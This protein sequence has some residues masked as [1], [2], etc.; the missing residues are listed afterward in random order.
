MANYPECP[1]CSDI[2][3]NYKS[4]IK[5]PKILD[6]GDSICKECLEKFITEGNEE[7]FSCPK[8][9]ENIKKEQNVDGY[10]TNKELIRI[11]NESF[12]IKNNKEEQKIRYD[13]ISLG[14]TGVGKTSILERL[15]KD[16][17]KEQVISTVGCDLTIYYIK[18]KEKKYELAFHDTS[19]QEK[20]RALTKN[21][22][23]NKDGVLFVYDIS[24]RESF[25]DVDFW[26]NSY[27]EENK[28]IVGL[29]IGNK[30]DQKREVEEEEAEIYA[31]KHGLKYFETSAKLDK[32]IKKAIACLL[33]LMIK[34]NPNKINYC[35]IDNY[36]SYSRTDE[37]RKKKKCC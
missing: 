4:H 30:C 7:F 2:Y 35:Q 3:G 6:C 32:K 37:I 16:N 24:D 33:E 23:R 8:C 12:N 14:Q 28:K 26:Y 22:L 31:K 36:S 34:S 27:K 1:K 29:L 5:A 18:Y 17:F 19:G 9:K 21:F 11:I 25:K 13:L 20:F 15:S 10:I